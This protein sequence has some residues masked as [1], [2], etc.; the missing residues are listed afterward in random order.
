VFIITSLDAREAAPAHLAGYVR[1][2]RTIENKVR[3]V[4]D[5]TLRV[6]LR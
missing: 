4:R 2:Q 3:Y 1:G 5:V 6:T